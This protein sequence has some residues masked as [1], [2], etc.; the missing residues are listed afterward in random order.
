MQMAQTQL[1]SNEDIIVINGGDG[2]GFRPLFAVHFLPAAHT[3]EM[4]G[5]SARSATAGSI[6][7]ARRVGPATAASAAART[8]AVAP[9]SVGG[10]RGVSP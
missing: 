10:S 6:R 2:R 5:Y 7:S 1:S 8:S 4:T 9:A 3:S